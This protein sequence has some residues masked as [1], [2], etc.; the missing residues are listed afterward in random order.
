M[1]AVLTVKDFWLLNSLVT[2]ARL[3]FLMIHYVAHLDLKIAFMIKLRF[4]NKSGSDWNLSHHVERG[5]KGRSSRHTAVSLRHLHTL[6]SFEIRGI[7]VRDGEY[8]I[9]KSSLILEGLKF[10]DHSLL[11]IIDGFET[12]RVMNSSGASFLERDWCL[13]TIARLLCR[14]EG[15]LN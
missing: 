3:G 11:S 14:F 4:F 5:P 7:L 15:L 6:L 8:R 9:A 10:I 12:R 1:D 2:A 13:K